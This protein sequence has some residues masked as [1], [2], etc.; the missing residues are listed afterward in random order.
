MLRWDSTSLGLLSIYALERHST[1]QSKRKI[2][3]IALVIS[4]HLNAKW[5]RS[6]IRKPLKES[7]QLKM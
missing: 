1:K 4:H 5:P 2:V 7:M 3:A 6:L